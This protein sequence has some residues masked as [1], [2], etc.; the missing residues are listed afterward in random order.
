MGEK[1]KKWKPESVRE[2]LLPAEGGGGQI[3]REE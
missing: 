1:R 2:A 3:G